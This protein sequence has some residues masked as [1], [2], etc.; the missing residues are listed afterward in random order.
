MR[1]RRLVYVVLGLWFGRWLAMELASYAGHRLL[2]PGPP[3]RD[4]PRR[5]GWMPGK[6]AE[7]PNEGGGGR[8]RA[9]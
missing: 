1:A 3:P 8:A 5:P 2:P 4:S 9:R 7:P 6:L